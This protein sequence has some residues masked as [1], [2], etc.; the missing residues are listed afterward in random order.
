MKS[1]DPVSPDDPSLARIKSLCVP[2][3]HSV[4]SLKHWLCKYEDVED[5]N[6]ASLFASVTSQTC[7]DDGGRISLLSNGAL[8]NSPE[9]PV[10]LFIQLQDPEAV[11]FVSL[12]P[13]IATASESDYGAI[14]FSALFLSAPSDFRLTVYY[15]IY[16]E[17]SAIPLRKPIEGDQLIA[18]INKMFVPPPQTLVHLQKSILR[19]ENIHRHAADLF[20]NLLSGSPLD[21]NKHISTVTA[22]LEEPIAL[23]IFPGSG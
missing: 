19:A 3:P 21:E 2:P 8:G 5:H 18:R 7:M 14:I 4:G 6:R 12:L 22:S 9:D 11:T 17:D 1:K 13:D 23:V 15:R 20:P 16:T 10:A